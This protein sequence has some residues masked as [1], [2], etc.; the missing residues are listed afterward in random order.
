MESEEEGES[1]AQRDLAIAIYR[2][3]R[4][5]GRGERQRLRKRTGKLFSKLLDT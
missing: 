3:G 2:R 4:V 1:V 5:S